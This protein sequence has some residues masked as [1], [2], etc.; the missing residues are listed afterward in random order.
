M[1]IRLYKILRR[2][3]LET[4]QSVVRGGGRKGDHAVLIKFP[5]LLRNFNAV[6]TAHKNVQ[7]NDC[8]WLLAGSLQKGFAALIF[9][10]LRL[11][12]MLH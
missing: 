3:Y 8:E 10:N 6:G 2:P 12:A 7:E 11:N 1:G 5:Q 4:L 9:H